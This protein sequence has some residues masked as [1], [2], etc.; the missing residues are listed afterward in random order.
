MRIIETDNFDGDYPDE[1][2][3]ALPSLSKDHAQAVAN[4]INDGFPKNYD[5]YYRVV[6]DNYKLVPGF[7]P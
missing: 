6:P 3:L 7:E 4:A 1:K 5:R 2:F